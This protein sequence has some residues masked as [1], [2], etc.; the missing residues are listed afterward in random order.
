MAK[1]ARPAT[2]VGAGDKNQTVAMVG[3]CSGRAGVSKRAK[4][5]KQKAEKIIDL[6]RMNAD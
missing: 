6:C 5:K 1:A 2:G 3:V 4:N